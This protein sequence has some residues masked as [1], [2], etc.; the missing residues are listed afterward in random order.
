MNH[1][2][3]FSKPLNCGTCNGEN[4]IKIHTQ[5][6]INSHGLME[7]RHVM[8]HILSIMSSTCTWKYVYA[9]NDNWEKMSLWTLHRKSPN[10]PMGPP[11]PAKV[12][13]SRRSTLEQFPTLRSHLCFLSRVE[14]E[15]P[16][17]HGPTTKHPTYPRWPITQY[18]SGPTF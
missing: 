4:H 17:I 10:L 11:G 14:D 5:N 13:G 12:A 8:K 16:R 15:V 6:T 3:R 7:E 2:R 18:G 9:G 1:C